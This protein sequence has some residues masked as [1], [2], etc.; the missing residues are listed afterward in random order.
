LPTPD[1]I[2]AVLANTDFTSFTSVIPAVQDVGGLEGVHNGVHDWFDHSVDSTM[3]TIAIASADPIFWMHHANIDRIWARW[4]FNNPGQLPNL[5]ASALDDKQQPANVMDPW[6][7]YT[8]PNTRGIVGLG[9]A[10]DG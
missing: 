3:N 10:Y 9:Y 7:R 6:T 8:E 4:Q 5:P 1:T 2:N